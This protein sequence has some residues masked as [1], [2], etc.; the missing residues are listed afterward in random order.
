[1][2]TRTN[3]SLEREPDMR[4][5]IEVESAVIRGIAAA[6]LHGDSEGVRVMMNEGVPNQIITRVLHSETQR[7]STDW[8]SC[9]Q[10]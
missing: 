9:N 8:K 3:D 7:R 1:M 4:S 6:L 5:N 2:D 10:Y